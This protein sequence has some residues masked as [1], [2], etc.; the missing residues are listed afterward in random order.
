MP[1]I[2]FETER[3]YIRTVKVSDYGG[4]KIIIRI[5]KDNDASRRVAEKCGGI[6]VG[7]ED[8]YASTV[9]DIMKERYEKKG[10]VFE[11]DSE[12]DDIRNLMKEG[13]E[14]VCI[15]EL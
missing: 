15:Y 1:Y 7:Y 9:F 11:N 5:D 6:L 13:K 4:V 3:L 2:E 12:Y 14:S 8:S 10:L